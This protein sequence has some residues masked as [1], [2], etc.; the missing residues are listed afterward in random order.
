MDKLEAMQKH[1]KLWT[2]IAK[3]NTK[4]Y[5][6][7]KGGT[8]IGKEE[9]FRAHCIEESE[10]PLDGCYACQFAS[11]YQKQS[12]I[13]SCSFCLVDWSDYDE[14]GYNICENGSGTGLYE[15]FQISKW[16]NNVQECARIAE[17]IANLPE[18][19]CI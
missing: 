7:C 4:I 16:S 6:E 18:N 13:S 15:Q 9:Y 14:N 5:N 19:E 2:W 3:E 1:H 11:E 17:I 12:D 10:R 8:P